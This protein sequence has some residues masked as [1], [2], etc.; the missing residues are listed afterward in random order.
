MLHYNLKIEV[1]TYLLDSILD[2]FNL[3]I[4]IHEG[5]MSVTYAKNIQFIAIVITVHYCYIS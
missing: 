1:G 5:K 4:E 2:G 3:K